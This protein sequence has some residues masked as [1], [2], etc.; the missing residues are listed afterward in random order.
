MKKDSSK[1]DTENTPLNENTNLNDGHDE[2]ALFADSF[3]YTQLRREDE[4]VRRKKQKEMLE[5][6]QLKKKEE[7]EAK[8]RKIQAEKEEREREKAEIERILEEKQKERLQIMEEK[9]KR[10][11]QKIREQQEHHRCQ[12]ESEAREE[13]EFNERQE[14][15]LKKIAEL[16]IQ[17]NN[18]QEDANGYQH[19][20]EFENECDEE[21]KVQPK[22]SRPSSKLKQMK[23]NQKKQKQQKEQQRSQSVQ[24]ENSYEKVEV[25]TQEN[26]QQVQPYSPKRQNNDDHQVF[27][28]PSPKKP[29]LVKENQS[30]VETENVDNEEA[31]QDS[32]SIISPEK[33]TKSFKPSS[34]LQRMQQKHKQ[35]NE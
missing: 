4:E 19:E 25:N 35:Q 24:E 20:Q 2:L 27:D 12:A 29:K 18:Q 7:L 9:K 26:D 16:E 11:E 13:A 3:R 14:A 30:Q 32:E 21:P 34:T 22:P 31:T 1:P 10:K 8:Q 33:S 6:E 5:K 28:M 17:E 23:K 15:E